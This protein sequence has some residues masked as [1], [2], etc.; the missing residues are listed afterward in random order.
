MRR[1]RDRALRLRSFA[2]PPM[3]RGGL[4]FDSVRGL[5]GPL[6]TRLLVARAGEVD[7]RRRDRLLGDALGRP[8]VA[9]ALLAEAQSTAPVRLVA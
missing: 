9:G 5:L 8:E 7:N 3:V 2:T 4:G 1:G 6:A